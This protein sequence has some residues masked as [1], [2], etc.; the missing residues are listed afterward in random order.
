MRLCMRSLRCL[1]LAI[2]SFLVL[3]PVY[4]YAQFPDLVV[5][6]GDTTAPSPHAQIILPIR[7]YNYAD[8][9]V[10]YMVTVKTDRPGLVLLSFADLDTVGTLTSGWQVL[11]DGFYGTSGIQISAIANAANP[12]YVPGIPPQQGSAPLIKLLVD[13]NQDSSYAVPQT[14]KIEIIK[15][16]HFFNFSD[17]NGKSIGLAYD[18]IIDTSYYNCI[19]WLINPGGD[20]T[21]N[22]WEEVPELPA[23]TTV[24]GPKFINHYLD[25]SIVYMIDGEVIIPAT[26]TCNLM[27]DVSNNGAVN[28]LDVTYLVNHL[29]RGSPAPPIPGQAD[30]NCD[31]SINILDA[32]CIISYLYNTSPYCTFCSC[33]EEINTC[34][35]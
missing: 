17:P 29:Y 24:I 13:I 15:D 25:T 23:D 1:L 9:V 22:E 4:S 20:S 2:I 8:T 28:L 19:D 3:F 32:T 10:G 5:Q 16:F 6:V 34:G 33:Q 7:M 26:G 18:T 27:G 14:A 30:V 35:N 21:C 12:P 11:Y 31:C